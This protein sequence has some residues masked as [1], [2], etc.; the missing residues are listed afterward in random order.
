MRRA[1]P[2]RAALLLLA[3]ACTLLPCRPARADA[4]GDL[5]ARYEK[6]KEKDFSTRMATLNEVAALGTEEGLRWLERVSKDDHDPSVRINALWSIAKVKLPQA[7]QSLLETFRKGDP[8]D[9]G[10]ILSAWTSYRTEDL[11]EDVIATAL[12]SKDVSA[13][14]SLLTVFARRNDARLLAECGRYLSDFPTNASSIINPLSQRMSPG[15]VPLLLAV[16]DDTKAYERD[17]VPRAFSAVAPDVKQALVDAITRGVEPT[18]TRAAQVAARA[19]I[20]E[21]EAALL[22]AAHAAKEDERKAFF[23]DAAARVGLASEEG[24]LLALECLK[25]PKEVLVLGGARALRVR[26]CPAAIPPL[27]KLLGSRSTAIQAEARVTLERITGQGFGDRADLWEAW[28]KDHG[29]TFDPASVKPPPEGEVLDRALVDLALE[30]GAEALR[31]MAAGRE[32]KSSKAPWEYASHPVG[33]TALVLLALHAVDP[34]TKD[35]VFSEGLRWLLAQSVPDSTYDAGIV[36]MAL[37]TIGGKKHA[38]KVKEAARVLLA[39][40]N[41][42][43]GWGYS[44]ANQKTDHSN[45]QYAILGLRHAVRAGVKVPEAAWRSAHAAWMRTQNP[46]GGWTYVPT[47]PKDTSTCSM[48]AA[49]LSSLL[50]CA[51]NLAL[52][53]ASREATWAAIDRGFVALGT[54]MK[55]G[56][57]SLYALYGVERAGVLGRRALL[58]T[59]PWYAPGAKRILDDQARD[60]LWTGTYHRAVDSALALL[61]LKKATA[62]IAGP[63]TGSSRPLAPPPA[64]ATVPPAPAPSAPAPAQPAPA[65]SQPAP[66]PTPEP[67][68]R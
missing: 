13:R 23:L 50:I 5:K 10:S 63:V 6:E 41:E 16:F 43:G 14:S 8:K 2:G 35:K 19:R 12:A 40:Q 52:D 64:P 47:G 49:G 34:D 48:T 32:A 67:A 15:A 22:G 28:W 17:N 33:T 45:G 56:T 21:A 62:P 58:G 60:G 31:A 54:L 20:A 26:P 9:R 66:A 68:A 59:V 55:V 29:D 25:S 24:R 57:D 7:G 53:D 42:Q 18:L 51:E 65:P 39:A 1:R 61:F 36:A 38:G 44:S 37:E 3:L 46:D 27:I 11:P 30:K 4:F